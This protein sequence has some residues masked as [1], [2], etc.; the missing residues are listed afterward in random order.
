MQELASQKAKLIELEAAI[1]AERDAQLAGLHEELG[2]DTREDLIAALRALGK[3]KAKAK[4]KPG[5]KKS[6]PVEAA[7]AG[8][9]KRRKRAKVTP[10]MRKQIEEA[11]KAGKTGAAIAKEFGVS[12]PTVQNI[13][14]AAGLTR[15]SK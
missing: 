3:G 15:N 9:K 12:L 14:R 13:K 2:Y 8:A 11:A 4:G 1:I 10:E 6:A 7:P 5:R